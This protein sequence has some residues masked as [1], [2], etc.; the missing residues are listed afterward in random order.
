M[1]PVDDHVTNDSKRDDRTTAEWVY[2]TNASPQQLVRVV[3]P[4]G[5]MMPPTLDLHRPPDG[6]V[7]FYLAESYRLPVDAEK[8]RQAREW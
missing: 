7:T 5:L 2:V 1:T 8:L 6:P 4:R 3:T